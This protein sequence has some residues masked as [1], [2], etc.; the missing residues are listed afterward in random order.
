MVAVVILALL[1]VMLCV[2]LQ[3]IQHIERQLAAVREERCNQKN[4]IELID[5]NRAICEHQYNLIDDNH[6]DKFFWLQRLEKEVKLLR[7]QARG[8]YIKF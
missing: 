2:L 3:R 7:R 1:A 8:K 4:L 5:R 6:F